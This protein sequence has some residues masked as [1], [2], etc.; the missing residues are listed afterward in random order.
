MNKITRDSL[1][2]LEA[3]A[4]A[5]P[6][7]RT[8]AIAHK[9]LRTV[10]IGDHVTLFFEDE[11]TCRYQIQEMLRIEKT[12]EEQGILDE[13]E[14]YNPLIPGGRD[15]RATMMIEYG[16]EAERRIALTKFKGIER[17]TWVQ[18]EGAKK[19]YAIAD[20]D[21]ERENETKTSAVHFMRFP[22][23]E[24]M[25]AALKYGVTLQMGVD[26]P[27]YTAAVDVNAETRNALVKDLK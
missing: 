24:E 11:L 10:H 14:A 26:H 12:F 17:K 25:A 20:E 22:L 13:L 18:V 1:M 6:E 4:K 16:D 2:T 3:Y 9:K 15:F 19:V 21:L 5:R 7:F 8:K 23:T 27:Q